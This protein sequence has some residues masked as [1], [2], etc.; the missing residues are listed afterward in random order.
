M[1]HLP[2]SLVSKSL[3]LNT[4]A[5]NVLQIYKSVINSIWFKNA[6]AQRVYYF[7]L[8]YQLL[9]VHLLNSFMQVF[10]KCGP[11]RARLCKMTF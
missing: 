1:Q 11:T 6:G 5:I 8:P 10:P 7:I 4:D 9:N 2:K 3:K